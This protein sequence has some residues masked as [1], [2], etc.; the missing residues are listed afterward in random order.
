MIHGID[1][2]LKMNAPGSGKDGIQ[3]R[4]HSFPQFALMSLVMLLR[5]LFCRKSF[6]LRTD[7]LGLLALDV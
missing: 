3:E 4:E 2:G 7:I 1:S 6:E 5:W